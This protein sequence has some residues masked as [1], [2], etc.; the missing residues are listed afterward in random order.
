MRSRVAILMGSRSDL[1]AMSEAFRILKEF[2]VEFEAYAMSAHRTADAVSEY[3]KD[4]E[5]RGIEV[6]ICGA[7][8]AAH[9]AGV[10]AAHTSLP[11]LGVPMKSSM[12]GLDSLLSTVQM[13]RG[14]PVATFAVGGAGAYN[15]GL[16]AIHIMSITDK[17]LA[18]KLKTFRANQTQS[19]LDR[20]EIKPEDWE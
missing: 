18:Q 17:T 1:E 6:L 20:A 11:V 3:V 9:L 8:G 7:G 14:I 4:L 10:C 12:N 16:F 15:A 13:P 2:D 19:V 5:K